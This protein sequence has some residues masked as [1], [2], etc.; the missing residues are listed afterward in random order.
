MI[1]GETY[2]AGACPFVIG[3][4]GGGILALSRSFLTSFGASA[5]ESGVFA[6]LLIPPFVSRLVAG[7]IGSDEEAVSV[8][9]NEGILSLIE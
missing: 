3:R 8:S 6:A 5:L 1:E 4:G 2:G 9:D 7:V